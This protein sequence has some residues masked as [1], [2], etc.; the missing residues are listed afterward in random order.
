MQRQ[1]RPLY[2]SKWKLILAYDKTPF[3]MFERKK[4]ILESREEM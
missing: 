2:V 1:I 4:L 3:L